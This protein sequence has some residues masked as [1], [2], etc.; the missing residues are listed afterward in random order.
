MLKTFR[1]HTNRVNQLAFSPDNRLLASASKDGTVRLW[2]VTTG[3][4][5]GEIRGH[6]GRSWCVAFSPDGAS[7]AT[8]GADGFVRLWHTDDN[9]EYQRVHLVDGGF[10]A[11]NFLPDDTIQ[12]YAGSAIQIL[13]PRSGTRVAGSG[14]IV[15]EYLGTLH[16][17]AAAAFSGDGETV[18]IGTPWSQQIQRRDAHSGRVLGDSMSV[19]GKIQD[20]AVSPDSAILAC[21]AERETARWIGLWDLV[22][23][24]QLSV[25]PLES[26]I[27]NVVFAPDGRTLY[28]GGFD[29]TI[30][31]WDLAS[32]RPLPSLEGHQ[33]G[34]CSLALS[35]DG[36]L[37][38]SGS[39]GRKVRLWDVG[40]GRQIRIL[41]GHADNVDALAFSPDGKTLASGSRDGSVK[42]WSVAT[43]LELLSLDLPLLSPAIECLRFSDN[44]ETLAAGVEPTDAEAEIYI[45]S[46]PGDSTTRAIQG[47]EA[48]P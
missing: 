24:R 34:I 2:D 31:R 47:A 40:A 19:Q 42:L 8:S 28:A 5:L 7:V 44:G 9:Q 12:M 48:T 10:L 32:R 6:L 22:S 18:A 1:G 30:Q 27:C 35:P 14:P 20:I 33:N 26:D 21:L 37:L 39:A 4:E 38:A 16:Y 29:H 23:G 36:R 43:G 15:E 13:D 17:A 25:F 3:A 41:I 46:A 45:W 11:M